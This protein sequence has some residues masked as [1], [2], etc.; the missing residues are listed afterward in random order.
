MS[1]KIKILTLSDHPLSPSGVGTQTRYVIEALLKTGKFQVLSLGGAI[2]HQDYTPKMVQPWDEDWKIIPVDGYGTQEMIRSILRNEKP[3]ILWMMTDPRFYEWLWAIENEIRPLVPIVYYHVWDNFPAPHFNKKFYESNDLVVAI[4]KLTHDIVKEVAPDVPLKYIPHAVREDVFKP[5]SEDE[6]SK[7]RENILGAD[8]DRFV[9]FWNNRNARRKQS[10]TL[11]WWWKEWLDKRD[12]HQKA[13]L[14]MH[15]EPKDPHGQDLGHIVKQLGLDSDRQVLFSTQKVPLEQMGNFYRI[16]D[17]TINI[18]DAEGFGLATL[19]SLSCGTPIIA[20]M[21][22]GLQEQVLGPE[23][24]NG[25]AVF[26]A[27]KAIIGSQQVPYI[28]EDRISKESFFAALDK[29]YFIDEK[30][31]RELGE[32][33]HRHVR[34]NYSFTEFEEQWVNTM[35]KVYEEEGSWETRKGYNGIV[36]KEVA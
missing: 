16:A 4:S 9:A 35:L 5:V 27:S 12:L 2:K 19:E 23:G 18:S 1:K 3:D 25:V 20:N 7:L 13:Q 33:G 32:Q 30:A 36:F 11:I 26:P 10:G 34:N 29:M 15:T 17:V 31:R 14:I 6:R 28:Y 24:E 8:K 21:T 22:G